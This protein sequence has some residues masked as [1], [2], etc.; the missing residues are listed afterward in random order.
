MALA[1]VLSRGQDVVPI[2]GTRNVAHFRE[3]IGALDVR[4]G[5]DHLARL[6]E[7]ATKVVG[8]RALRPDDIG[9]ETPPQRPATH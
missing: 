9:T 1:W 3:N 6:E 4:L 7:I 8:F 2:P 5:V